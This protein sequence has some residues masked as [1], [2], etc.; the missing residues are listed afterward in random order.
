MRKFLFG[1]IFWT[2]GNSVFA[3]Q[4]SE[5]SFSTLLRT[6]LEVESPAGKPTVSEM[7]LE[8]G[9]LI[10]KFYADRNFESAWSTDGV[11]SELAYEMR[12]EIL[13]AKFDG[14]SPE[15]YQITLVNTYFQTF[16]A[17]KAAKKENE[18]GDMVSLELLL[19]NAFFGLSEDLELGKVDPA[20]LKGE[21]E[22]ERK[23]AQMNYVDL[24]NR[25]ILEQDIRRNL[26][27]LYPRFTI[28]KKGREV[29]RAMDE[30]RKTDT[31]DW[32]VVK[33][34]KSIKVG[35]SHAAIPT[36]R[37]RLNYWGYAKDFLVD[38]PKVYDSAMY[39]GVKA[40]QQRNGM[41]PDGVIG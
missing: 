26:E 35:D 14:L 3:F 7:E 11:L 33:L 13:Q 8:S 20:K 39:L 4:D 37:E 32:K 12:F 24:L 2:L 38:D 15:D 30:R 6:K 1:F 31:L 22:I 25:S 27:R 17:N 28:Y 40:F 18:I 10:H 21:W 36:L 41:E 9:E 34:E 23:G 19:T 29:L 5:D 16:E